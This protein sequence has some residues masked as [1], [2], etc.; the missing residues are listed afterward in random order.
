MVRLRIFRGVAGPACWLVLLA[1]VVLSRHANGS[2]GS[3]RVPA[4]PPVS[5]ELFSIN[6]IQ[7]PSFEQPSVHDLP[8]LS[9]A[10]GDSLPY[11]KVLGPVD[12]ISPNFWRASLGGQSLDLDGCDIGG[13]T[14]VVGTKPGAEYELCFA[15]A[16]SPDGPP[17][18]KTVE[19]LWE[20]R[21]L[22]T[23]AI[24]NQGSTRESMNWSYHRFDVKARRARTALTFQSWTSGCYGVVID[25]VKLQEKS[26]SVTRSGVGSRPVEEMSDITLHDEGIR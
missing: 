20:G 6:L 9:L 17:R 18:V 1:L 8:Y 21:T 2:P 25:D 4:K 16:A 24:S 15:L 13:I 23:L 3:D 7:N 14:Q 26:P 19:I 11:W 12:L 22:A 5:C 10:S